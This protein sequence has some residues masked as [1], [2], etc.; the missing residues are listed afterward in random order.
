MGTKG[1]GVKGG[2]RG[3]CCHLE[4]LSGNSCTETESQVTRIPTCILLASLKLDVSCRFVRR[5]SQSGYRQCHS[6]QA[7]KRRK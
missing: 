7:S 6:Q 2:G 5:G 4:Q 1:F 3:C